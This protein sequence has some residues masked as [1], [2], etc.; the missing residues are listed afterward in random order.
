MSLAMLSPRLLSSYAI[1][2]LDKV[3][4]DAPPELRGALEGVI[5]D[6]LPRFTQLRLVPSS[7]LG[8][9]LAPWSLWRVDALPT[10]ERDR[11]GARF[12]WR[13]ASIDG[14][15]FVVPDRPGIDL[16][17]HYTVPLPPDFRLVAVEVT[18]GDVR[19]IALLT[20]DT[21]RVAAVRTRPPFCVS[22]PEIRHLRINASGPFKLQGWVVHEE[23]VR[24]IAGR[25]PDL[26]FGAPPLHGLWYAG[27]PSLEDPWERIR[28][29]APRR[30]TPVD[31]PEG[32]PTAWPDPAAAEEA[33]V[34]CFSQGLEDTFRHFARDAVLPADQKY[35][36][37]GAEGRVTLNPMRALLL[38]SMDPG[39][40]RLLGLMTTLKPVDLIETVDPQ[41]RT[42]WVAGAPFLRPAI[43]PI[44]RD[45]D[46]L[47]QQTIA[48]NPAFR[49]AMSEYGARGLQVRA[50]LTLAFVAP[51][52]DRPEV[53]SIVLDG[54]SWTRVGD[55]PGNV[56][57]QGFR[58]PDPPVAVLAALARR[59]GGAWVSR[60]ELMTPASRR[61]PL[62]LGMPKPSLPPLPSQP[63][64]ARL[65]DAKIP[66]DGAPWPYRVAL[67]DLFGRFG[68]SRDIDV[69]APP[70]PDVPR[71]VIEARTQP[72]DA[73]PS[74]R[75]PASPG[76]L[77]LVVHVPAHADLAAGSRA[78][79]TVHIA[80]VPGEAAV[81]RP[82]NAG[83]LLVSFDLPKCAPAPPAEQR[84]AFDVE[85]W[86]RD[87]AGRPGAKATAN[88]V[89]I[90]SRPPE[91]PDTAAGLLWTSR[92]GPSPEVELGLRLPAPKGSRWRVYVT[93]LNALAP[94]EAMPRVRAVAA[95]AGRRRVD[96]GRE[97]FRLLTPSPLEVTGTELAFDTTLPRALQTVQ[98][99]RFV[100]INEYGVEAKFRECPMLPVA[101]PSDRRPP[102]PRV[103]VDADADA[104]VRMT[105]IAE[106]L[107][108]ETLRE[109]EP[110]LFRP[111]PAEDARAP[112][113]RLRRAT[114]AVADP[115]Y[116]RELVLGPAGRRV[117]TLAWSAS[118][119][120]FE[121]TFEDA[122]AEP[123]V[124]YFYW[125]E[126]RMPAE[127]R[128]RKGAAE[129]PF[130]AGAIRP[131]DDL[132]MQD[133]P[134]AFSEAS[135]AAMAMAVP[136]RIAVL[137]PAQ[138]TATF[139]GLAGS[140]RLDLGVADGPRLS[141]RAIGPYA[142]RV[143]L[144]TDDGDLSLADT[145]LLQEGAMTYSRTAPGVTPQHVQLGLVLVDPL[146][147]SGRTTLLDAQKV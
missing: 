43:D 39:A 77:E 41:R 100:P 79:D 68:A 106:G 123:F 86:F 2:S 132:Q 118:G 74:G 72:R 145:V 12:A 121:A 4:H 125:A 30:T 46:W 102:A 91:V 8:L 143:Y 70:R 130:P 45:D 29:G 98:F 78:L 21:Q 13:G 69:P 42:C 137:R 105:I 40:A 140:W 131:V 133:A 119:K 83:R 92:P 7:L 107:D 134:G 115:V 112:E 146:G 53:S 103:A 24:A 28:R 141:P 33:R 34:R 97:K 67:G 22:G 58:L 5:D 35:T 52:P 94:G 26:R 14:H 25:P 142:V 60:S 54:A 62:L 9:P 80:G 76:T 139:T 65:Y 3:P 18:E 19:S 88:V 116:A 89:A 64:Y 85:V 122:K 48:A 49:D 120:R 138:L 27:D 90:D 114:G 73:V 55:E 1:G 147:R 84:K 15:N 44:E 136:A 10:S 108:E 144:H 23:R 128:L 117:A 113:Y 129:E 75:A 6:D 16:V 127:R 51:P 57:R 32:G 47:Q 101:V 66:G 81:T 20:T 50:Y 126:V 61:A 111:T 96:A 59:E 31:Q 37:P 135:P 36:P 110:G 38:Q 17:G 104:R 82:A 87:D 93:D 63:H 99:L 95:D 109:R 124:R 56:F 71:P 11:L